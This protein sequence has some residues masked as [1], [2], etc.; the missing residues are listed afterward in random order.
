MHPEETKVITRPE[1]RH[2][3]TLLRLRR[4]GAPEPELEVPPGVVRERQT[5]AVPPVHVE[6]WAHHD[7]EREDEYRAGQP[8]TAR[9]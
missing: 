4:R 9:P 1:P 8:R 6:L 3:E 5:V 7:E 2:H